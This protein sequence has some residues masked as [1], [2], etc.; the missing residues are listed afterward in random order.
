MLP[1]PAAQGCGQ[2]RVRQDAECGCFLFPVSCSLFPVPCSLFFPT[3]NRQ[4]LT[5]NRYSLPS[6]T[7]SAMK[8]N[9]AC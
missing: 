8:S 9:S 3:A 6:P 7:T 4:P 1:V 2:C 5:A